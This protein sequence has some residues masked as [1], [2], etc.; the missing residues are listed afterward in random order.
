MNRTRILWYKIFNLSMYFFFI[1]WTFFKFYIINL[2]CLCLTLVTLCVT[3]Q[4]KAIGK[5]LIFRQLFHSQAPKFLLLPYSVIIWWNT[6]LLKLFKSY[7]QAQK[8][9]THQG[10]IL[11]PYQLLYVFT[12]GMNLKNMITYNNNERSVRK[13]TWWAAIRQTETFS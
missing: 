6:H 13:G 1:F 8:T 10:K 7:F 12:R 9:S 3:Y 2:S 5:N 11:G 4:E